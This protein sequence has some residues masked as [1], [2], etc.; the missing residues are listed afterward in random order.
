MKRVS[1][2]RAAGVNIILD[3]FT[4][5]KVLFSEFTS[6]PIDGV[7]VSCSSP[8]FFSQD[9]VVDGSLRGAISSLNQIG[10]R[11][12]VKGSLDITEVDSLFKYGVDYFQGF[13]P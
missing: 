9:S 12:F 1:V 11:V 4:G 7:R 2:I 3:G 10:H 13:L 6:L 8:G 5:S